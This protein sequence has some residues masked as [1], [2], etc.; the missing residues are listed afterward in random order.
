[1]D[2]AGRGS[3][4]DC[5]PWYCDRAGFEGVGES[6]RQVMALG[7]EPFFLPGWMRARQ[8]VPQRRSQGGLINAARVVAGNHR[9]A[10]EQGQSA[11]CRLYVQMD[12]LRVVDDPD[13]ISAS[14]RG[15]RS[16]RWS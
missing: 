3:D 8:Q 6:T 9:P 13:G 4:L 15:R 5:Y 12:R 10:R 11:S 2:L 7:R 16:Q 14:E 1:M